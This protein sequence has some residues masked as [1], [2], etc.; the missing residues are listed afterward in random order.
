MDNKDEKPWNVSEDS[1]H[2]EEIVQP[3]GNRVIISWPI[4]YRSKDGKCVYT[5]NGACY[6]IGS[7]GKI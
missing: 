5:E 6:Y 2:Y 3:N 7:R 1:K 4:V